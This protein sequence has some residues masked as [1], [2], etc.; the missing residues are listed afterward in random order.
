MDQ[1]RKNRG[2]SDQSQQEMSAY[3]K[4]QE[5]I[6]SSHMPPSYLKFKVLKIPALSKLWVRRSVVAE[7]DTGGCS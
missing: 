1:D 2:K 3:L 6:Q 7:V 4:Q 5:F